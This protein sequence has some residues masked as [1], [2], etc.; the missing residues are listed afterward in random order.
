MPTIRADYWLPMVRRLQGSNGHQFCS[1]V[2]LKRWVRRWNTLETKGSRWQWQ[3]KKGN[4]RLEYGAVGKMA[5]PK[6]A[7]KVYKGKGQYPVLD[8]NIGMPY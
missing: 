2:T 5:P 4:N 6:V 3:R 8:A 7:V 1:S